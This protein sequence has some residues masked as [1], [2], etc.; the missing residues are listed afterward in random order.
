MSDL[1]VPDTARWQPLRIGLIDLFYYDDEEFPFVDGRLLLRGN[2][3]TGKSKV[4]ALTLPF[5]LDGD[6]SARRVEPDADP[7]KRMEWNLLL[8]GEHPHPERLGYTWIE[9][10]R[11]TD[12]GALEFCTLGAGLKAASGRGMVRH[13]F[14]VTD[15]RVGGDL[16]LLDA[17]RTALSRER[18]TEAIGDRG[19]VYDHKR[20]YRRAVDERLF[21]LGERR[22]D[23]L[24]DLLVQLRQPQLSKR[25]NERALSDAL[26]ESLP[27]VRS[28][29]VEYVAE[30]FRG[31]DDERE[32][33]E[34]LADTARAT[35]SFLEHY[36]R[37]AEV[38][39]KRR[40]DEPRRTQS[41]FE[42]LG[43]ELVR[44]HGEVDAAQQAVTDARTELNSLRERSAVL[45]AQYEALVDGEHADAEVQ[46]ESAGRDVAAAAERAE[47]AAGQAARAADDLSRAQD[48]LAHA[49]D[50]ADEAATAREQAASEA[51]SAAASAALAASHGD[52]ATVLDESASDARQLADETLQRRR[53]G[54]ARVRELISVAEA[55]AQALSAAQRQ[56]D[57]AT[58]HLD[59]A[60][61]RRS[62]ADAAR[63]DAAES[64][65]NET[66][67]YL[68]ALTE[69]RLDDIGT[70]VDELRAWVLTL[71][72]HSPV[73]VALDEAAEQSRSDLS[74]ERARARSRA[75]DLTERADALA[76]EIAALDEGRATPPPARHTRVDDMP[77]LPLWRAV[78]FVDTDPAVHAG[79]EAALEAAGL[80]D[81]HILPGGELRSPED[82][83]AL[84]TPAAQKSAPLPPSSPRTLAD[85][86]RPELPPEQTGVATS[87]VL[88]VLHN[89]AVVDPGTGDT[90]AGDVPSWVSPDGRFGLGVVTG[91]WSKNDASYIGDGAREAA[92]QRRLGEARSE[93]DDVRAEQE[94]VTQLIDRL[95]RRLRQVREERARLPSE[96]PV[97]D[98]DAALD[99]A[100]AA[101][102]DATAVRD[103]AAT[104][105]E[106]ARSL[107]DTRAAE[108]TEAAAALHLPTS[109]AELDAI[110]DATDAY[111]EA[112]QHLWHAADLARRE[113]R[114]LAAAELDAGNAGERHTAAEH[115]HRR[116]G[117]EHAAARTR[118]ETLE[119]TVGAEV[120]EFQ[121]RRAEVSQARKNTDAAIDTTRDTLG[122]A[123]QAEAVAQERER[124]V[125]AQ[126]EDAATAR[127]H[128]IAALR[129][130]VATGLVTVAVPDLDIPDSDAEW[131]VSQAV[132]LAR[133][134]DQE[135]ASTNADDQAWERVQ[136]KL[137]TEFTTLQ[138]ALS[139][140]GHTAVGEPS[141]DGYVVTVVFGGKTTPVAELAATL[142]EDID[143]RERLLGAREREIIENHLVTEIGANLADL[144]TEA[145]S[146]LRALNAELSERPTSTGMR[147]RVVWQP[148]RDGPA[149]LAD[150]RRRL[151]QMADA[152]SDEDRQVIGAFLQSRIADVRE[153]DETGTWYE[154]LETALDYRAWHHFVVE[155][156]QNG[157]WRPAT[158]PASGGERVLAVSL[159]LFAAASSHY[160]SAGKPHAARLVTLD[161]AFAGVDDDSRA[162]SLG[163][164][165][166][167]DL[168]V[169]MTSEREW[170]CYPEV[171]GL[172]IA[173]LSRVEGVPAVLVS[174]WEWD[175]RTRSQIDS[176]DVEPAAAGLWD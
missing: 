132:G 25:P 150:A 81:A 28:D 123:Q 93:L 60:S 7:N 108:L 79:L 131:S 8:G 176:A 105:V 66:G 22:Y 72:G 137:S 157:S 158:G 30:G 86:L 140:H 170:A 151:L 18:L 100:A 98:A 146:H 153:T 43:R 106:R 41:T 124:S 27:P 17:S 56:L 33:L 136:T 116:R 167:F 163:L 20:D 139:R 91:A 39:S 13:W 40:A 110:R 87:D 36:R 54:L 166:S 125:T 162:K 85:L 12:D 82:G 107:A 145:E 173:Q 26:T 31:L 120:R 161:E 121:R 47:E 9:F 21:G 84:L 112:L 174:R 19:R 48:S 90:A 148:R 58:S 169:V 35:E 141:D 128:A 101:V 74:D 78:D 46:L 172:S 16:Q 142:R 152:W 6:L 51:G 80:L 114:T 134:I 171:P 5:L 14:F 24:V 115:A 117:D 64:L 99:A 126:Q 109:L 144:V 77:G 55:A 154:H 88:T 49:R 111:A 4:L 75:G 23:A 156:Y 113:Q 149:G 89:I 69:L 175:G 34:E 57:D 29:L 1:P 42:H 164:L 65:V 11:R 76:D 122:E 2:N 103:E 118:L 92:R 68:N 95:D 138:A 67:A 44:L 102:L 71:E 3:G 83:E 32:Q 160:R 73:E 133:S 52:V 127:E 129:R 37:Y 15:Q 10:G 155:R 62:Q 94:H 61:A 96:R 159:P 147:L 50:V 119:A 135:L 70:V 143:A 53:R 38:I 168:D 165:H 104:D 59:R 63:N 130:T 45:E 97:R